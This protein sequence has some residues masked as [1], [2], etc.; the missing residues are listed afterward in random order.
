VTAEGRRA[1]EELVGEFSFSSLKVK[2]SLYTESA[3]LRK[4]AIV[5][6]SCPY[7]TT[8]LPACLQN[9]A[10]NLPGNQMLQI[11]ILKSRTV[12]KLGTK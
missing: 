11:Y 10:V 7:Q 9:P 2:L 12:P 6:R 5:I 3:P 8:H 4:E 1:G